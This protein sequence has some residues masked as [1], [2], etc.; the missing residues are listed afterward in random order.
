MPELIIEQPG[1]PP[2]TV[3]LTE[4][5]T[6][7]GRA[8]DNK[9][10][11][12]AEEVSRYHAKIRL[13]KEKT[14]LDDLKS[15]NGTY[16]NRQRIVERVLSDSDEVWFGGKCRATFKDDSEEILEKRKQ[17]GTRTKLTN[18][19]DQV[20]QEMDHV[21]A[22]MTMIARPGQGVATTPGVVPAN[23]QQL[24]VEKMSRA[25]R[26][27]DALYQASK[28][29]ASDFD[30]QKRI[31]DVLDLA[32]EVTGAERGFL[33]LRDQESSELVAKVARGMDRELEG[34]SPSMGIARKAAIEG[35]PV[36]M[37]DSGAD[38]QFGGRESIIRQRILSAMCVPLTVED[39]ILGSL[40]VDSRQ[41]GVQFDVADLDLFQAMASQSAMAIE[42][43]QLY[44]QMLEA[45]K[46]RANFGRFLSPAVV[47]MVMNEAEEVVLGGRKL[48]VTT[49]YCDI[50]GF[51]PLS[52]G[53]SPGQLVDLLNEH[54]TA[55][56]RIIF[57]CR[58]TLDKFIGDEVMA[59]FGA[60]ISGG[61]D[62]ANAVRA[63]IIMQAKN[64]ELNKRR[65]NGNLPTFEVGIGINSGDVFSG[66][67][68]SPDRLDFTV[69]GDDVNIASRLCS[70]AKAGQ[71]VVGYSTHEL[72]KN[73]VRT[74][75]IGTPVLKGKSEPIE[76]FEILGIKS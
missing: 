25:F 65:S 6:S 7:F 43:A 59:L 28:I 9:I 71:I 30:V 26:R 31:S 60:P 1:I 40:Y 11:L 74:K 58:G 75:S 20:R 2:M 63:A 39:R 70:V 3:D 67:V 68:G 42:N 64:A 16:V 50:R 61:N 47:E 10:V 12:V 36:L 8:D 23:A 21:S 53:L 44:E 72:V 17:Q 62:A 22:S 5:E 15:L 29:M 51:T 35:E 55:M 13:V 56:T 41:A 37:A 19:L 46:K 76:A 49:L 4:V 69:I 32:M 54:F 24:E 34:S 38:A 45:E 48:P 52:E 57:D 66:F 27:L 18:G 73:F 33:M 14:I